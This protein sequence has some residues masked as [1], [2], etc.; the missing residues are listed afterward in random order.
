MGRRHRRAAIAE[1]HA[2]LPLSV[3]EDTA[4]EDWPKEREHADRRNDQAADRDRPEG[5]RSDV[6]NPACKREV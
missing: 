5:L 2:P 3:A 4:D 6:R 1:E